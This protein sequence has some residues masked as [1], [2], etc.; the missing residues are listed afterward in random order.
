MLVPSSCF[1]VCFCVHTFKVNVHVVNLAVSI[2]LGPRM[3]H[4][5]NS[6]CSGSINNWICMLG[7][8]SNNNNKVYVAPFELLQ[9]IEVIQ[10]KRDLIDEVDPNPEFKKTDHR[11][12]T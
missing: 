4:L 2:N 12:I 6:C 10:R 5:K 11:K 9:I 1:Q 8:H 3:I 7:L